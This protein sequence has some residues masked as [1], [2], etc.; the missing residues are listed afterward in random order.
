MQEASTAEE[1][2]Q[3]GI[4]AA[5]AGYPESLALAKGVRTWSTELTF[6]LASLPECC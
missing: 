6:G 5:R 3:K 2:L 4:S 1:N